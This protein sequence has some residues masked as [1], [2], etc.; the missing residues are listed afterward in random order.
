NKPTPPKHYNS[1]LVNACFYMSPAYL[2]RV[3]KPP[4]SKRLHNDDP[5]YSRVY[6][7]LPSLQLL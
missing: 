4:L 2:I 1:S 7:T 6:T 3:Q 5:A